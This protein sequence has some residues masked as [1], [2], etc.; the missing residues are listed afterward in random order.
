M[1]ANELAS[2][3][4]GKASLV[5]RW[6]RRE[7]L[8]ANYTIAVF[9]LIPLILA[10]IQFDDR[11][12]N[13]IN[14]WIKS[15]KFNIAIVIYLGTLTWYCG[16][17]GAR[18]KSHRVYRLYMHVLC[19]TL[20]FMLPWLYGAAILGEPAHYNRTHVVLAPMYALMGIVSVMFTTGT[21]VIGVLIA[22]SR[23]PAITAFFRYAVVWSL[24]VSFV[25]TVYMASE[26]A[27]LDSHWIGGSQTD[28]NG[29]WGLGWSR[30]GGDLRVAH[31]FSLHAMQI[32]PLFAVL[33]L[34]DGLS[35]RPHLAAAVLSLAYC[36]FLLYVYFQAKNGQPFLPWLG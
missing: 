10:A 3:L 4:P 20:V 17:I 11:T 22:I 23:H 2:D 25:F 9:L 28:L 18:I 21:I 33:K 7:P 6:Y 5:S 29:L 36:T 27:S 26:L 32:I 14:I 24:C 34:P 13:G 12:L 15:L 1:L 16:W 19:G 31:F 30:D 35:M 8:L